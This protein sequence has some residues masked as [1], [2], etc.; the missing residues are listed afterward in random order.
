MFL[1]INSWSDYYTSVK[2]DNYLFFNFKTH[3]FTV[4][5]DLLHGSHLGHHYLAIANV[6]CSK[7]LQSQ[8][9]LTWIGGDQ[10]SAKRVGE[11]WIMKVSE[12]L[13]SNGITEKRLQNE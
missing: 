3:N 5:V 8:I 11:Y 13:K 7:Q 6:M 2:G 12:Y 4:V 9:T 1:N 10:N